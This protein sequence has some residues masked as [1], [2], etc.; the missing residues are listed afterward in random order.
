[1]RPAPGGANM[2][3]PTTKKTIVKLLH[4]NFTHRHL[5][6]LREIQTEFPNMSLEIEAAQPHLRQFIP[7]HGIDLEDY[8]ALRRLNP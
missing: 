8:N 5:V 6:L 4:F 2:R 7:A 1:M 3:V